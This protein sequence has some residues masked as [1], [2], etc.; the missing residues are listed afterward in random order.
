VSI[1]LNPFFPAGAP[2]AAPPCGADLNTGSPGDSD[3]MKRMRIL[4][5]CIVILLV[6]LM[7][8]NTI[9]AD[10]GSGTGDLHLMPA[11]RSIKIGQGRLAIDGSFRI[12]I[13]GQTEPRIAK[14]ASRLIDHLGRKTG[15]PLSP[16]LKAD[17]H[18][19]SF[20]IHCLGP[21][22]PV[23]SVKENESYTLDI[24]NEKARLSAATPVGIIRGMETFL[25]LVELDDKSF[26]VPALQIEDAP[27]FPWRGILIDVSRHWQPADV[28][29]RNLDAMAAVKM[30][31]FHWHLSDDQG[32]RI[33]SVRFPKLQQLGS[34]GCFYSQ[35]EVRS[36]VAYARDRGIRV[37]PEFDMPGHTTAWLAAY[38]GLASA[39]GPYTIERA[40]G[41]FDPTMDPSLSRL[42]TFLDSFIGEMAA[43]FPDEYFH[44]GGDEVNGKQWNASTRIR[45]FK[46]QKQLADNAA[47]QAYF[48]RR[49]HQILEKHGKKMIGWDEIFH[50]DL[51]KTAMVQSWRGQSYLAKAARQGYAGVLSFGYYLDQMQPASYHYAI[52]PLGKEAAD[53]TEAEKSRILGG[54]VCM[55]GEY[56]TPENIDSRIWPRTAAIAERLW[57]PQQQNDIQDMYRRLEFTDRDLDALGLR[58]RAGY[59]QML[60]RMTGDQDV[61]PLKTLGDLLKPGSLSTR[62][63]TRTYTSLSPLNRMADAVRPESDTAR[64]FGELVSRANQNPSDSA[65]ALEQLHKLLLNWSRNAERLKPVIDNSYLLEEIGPLSETVSE[66]SA[67]GLQAMDYLKSGRKPP[68]G[69]K[70]KAAATI[71]RAN[72]PQAEMFISI[73]PGVKALVEAAAAVP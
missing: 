68:E 48:N 42:Y 64:R 56:V 31:V 24:S 34:E 71:E 69:W 18:A 25:Q 38:P 20:E 8:R 35:K 21:G 14:A 5:F 30:N 23:Q 9:A 62:H 45:A 10:A 65:V 27:R 44:V 57:S 49:L 16:A 28:I 61:A 51:P 58:H 66:L 40:W 17:T 59:A 22:E 11:P 47:L 60:Q 63:R 37:V 36:I 67:A 54:E 46:K 7:P 6:A 39:P 50:P 41:I 2:A 33:E 55:W 70:E 52:D 3:I 32:F 19:A 53:L 29:L 1:K 26:F 73:A 15:I 12:S 4:K 43:L 72:K 13:T